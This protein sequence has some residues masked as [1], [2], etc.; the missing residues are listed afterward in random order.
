MN[1]LNYL[2]LV[3]IYFVKFETVEKDTFHISV[4]LLIVPL[5]CVGLAKTIHLCMGTG[6]GKCNLVFPNYCY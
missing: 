5:L 1:F 6:D 2:N 3:V 4:S